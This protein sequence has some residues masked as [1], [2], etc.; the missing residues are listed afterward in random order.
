MTAN[1]IPGLLQY[2][3]PLWARGQDA[4]L[5]ILGARV[6]AHLAYSMELCKGYA[7]LNSTVIIGLMIHVISY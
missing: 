1:T 4:F 3:A 2:S 7:V 6:Q 5:V